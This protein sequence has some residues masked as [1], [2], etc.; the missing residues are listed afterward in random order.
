M[1]FAN[2][3]D[4][5]RRLAGALCHLADEDVVVLG[6]PRGGVP[7]AAEVARELHKPLDIILVR[8]LGVPFQRELA[9]GA[10][11]EGG[12]RVIDDEVVR[13]TGVRA[14]DVDKAQIREQAELDRRAA[15]F[16]GTRERVPIRGRTALIVDDGIATGSTVRAACGV[17]RA[18]GAVRVVVATPV[19]PP[20]AVT[21]LRD[22]AD[23]VVA[24]Q[25]PDKFFAIGEF[26][27]DFTQTSDDEVVRLLGPTGRDEDVR[28]RAGSTTLD[29]HLTVPA[30][31]HAIVVFAHGS[32]S[33]RH[34]PRN[35][36]VAS[37]LHEAGLGTLLFDLLTSEEV[38]AI[39][40]R[41]GRPDLAA[42]SLAGVRAPTLLIVG[43]RDTEVLELNRKA[44]A[45]LRCETRISVVPGA[46]H[47]F[48]E[49][50]TLRV[51]AELARDW[52]AEHLSAVEDP[53]S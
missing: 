39:V 27:A 24:V 38:L 32:G 28:V 48:E 42:A 17:A 41:G 5:G 25:T 40:S 23:E 29:G 35:Q 52:F 34:S 51:A 7:V 3:V 26:Y 2:R 16:R 44:Q 49:P 33:S 22:A 45:E 47:L 18:A 8:K 19:A 31:A 30:G 21:S 11:G 37:V 15:R 36:Y 14:V 20:H 9:M 46:S 13:L 12:V 1:V 6:L 53:A 50:G 4:A 43:A 10:I